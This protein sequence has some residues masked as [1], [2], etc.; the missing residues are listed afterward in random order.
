MTAEEI[1]EEASRY[2]N[3]HYPYNKEDSRD[4]DLEAMKESIQHHLAKANYIA[5]YKAGYKQAEQDCLSDLITH[6]NRQDE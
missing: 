6:Q 4:G 2:A 5:G 3:L 1:Q